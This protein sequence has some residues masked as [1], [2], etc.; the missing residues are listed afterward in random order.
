[1]FALRP[2]PGGQRQM[3]DAAKVLRDLIG[4]DIPYADAYALLGEIYL[5]RTEVNDALS[6]YRAG[7][8]NA[9]LPQSVRDDFRTMIRQI[10]GGL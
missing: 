2:E 10:E 4:R 9:N 6:V 5:E 8:R 3:D 1:M 7:S